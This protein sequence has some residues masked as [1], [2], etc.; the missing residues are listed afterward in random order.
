MRIS[1]W[2]SDVCSSDL[3]PYQPYHRYRSCRPVPPAVRAGDAVSAI[4]R[5]AIS[6]ANPALHEGPSPRNLAFPA[7][8]P[9]LEALL[10]GVHT[11]KQVHLHPPG[12]RRSQE[13][14]RASCRES[15][16]VRVD[17]GGRR[18]IKKKKTTEQQK[19]T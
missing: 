17:H 19:N 15:V 4:V 1:D 7:P 9:W 13:I 5:H 2:S 6:A 3:V 16:S 18:I 10:T 14:G 12:L 8:A 11:P